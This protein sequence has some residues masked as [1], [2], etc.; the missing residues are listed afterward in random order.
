MVQ[1]KLI[2]WGVILFILTAVVSGGWLH[3]TG[4]KSDLNAAKALATNLQVKNL[5]LRAQLVEA[6]QDRDALVSAAQK[7]AQERELIREQLNGAIRRLRAQKPPQECTAAINWAV[8]QKADM[9]W[10]DK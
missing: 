3:Y 4:M 1:A 8:E 2:K 9:G 10:D 6:T 5:E 7:A